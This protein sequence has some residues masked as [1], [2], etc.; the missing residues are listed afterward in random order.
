MLQLSR[1][2]NRH[3]FQKRYQIPNQKQPLERDP[4]EA[5]VEIT[6]NS[7]HLISSISKSRGRTSKEM[8]KNTRGAVVRH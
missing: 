2:R 1:K 4:D 7:N 5:E 3:G 8:A 6:Q